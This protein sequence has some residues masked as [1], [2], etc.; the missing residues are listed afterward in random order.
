VLLNGEDVR[1]MKELDT[2]GMDDDELSILIAL[3]GDDGYKYGVPG[4]DK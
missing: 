3:A 1:F 2:P 4:Y